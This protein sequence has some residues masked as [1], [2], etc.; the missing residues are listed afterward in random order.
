MIC[1][2]LG[3]FG[4]CVGSDFAE[5]SILGSLE[6]ATCYFGYII[7]KIIK[8]TYIVMVIYGNQKCKMG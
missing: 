5:N 4:L 3:I 8:N 7:I 2:I 1:V 6:D